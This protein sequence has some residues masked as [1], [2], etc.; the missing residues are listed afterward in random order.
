MNKI[1][2]KVAAFVL[3]L[4]LMTA[5]TNNDE[6]DNGNTASAGS[7]Y[8]SVAINLNTAGGSRADG[9]EDT[10]GNPDNNF[11]GKWAGKDK[12]KTIDVYV[13]NNTDRLE[14]YQSF[15]AG[16]FQVQGAAAD[17]SVTITPSKGIKVLPGDKKVYVVVNPTTETQNFLPHVVNTTTLTE[18]QAKYEN[19]ADVAT[20][21]L[22]PAVENNL[23]ATVKTPA[24]KIASVDSDNTDVITMTAIELASVTVVDNVSEAATLS[25]NTTNRAKLTVKRAV[26]RVMVTTKAESFEIKGDDALTAT[27]ETDEVLGTI[28]NIK[29]V[30][31]QGEKSLYFMQRKGGTTDL[32]YKTPNSSYVANGTNYTWATAGSMYD[33]SGLWKNSGSTDIKGIPVPTKAL[34]DATAS[35][36]LSNITADLVTQLNGEFI[37]PNTHTWGATQDASGYRKANTAYILVRAQFTPK[38]VVME[39][40]NIN[41]AYTEGKTFY[42]GANGV[43]YE[44]VTAAR[45]AS[46]KG[47]AGQTAAKYENGKVLYFAWINPDH[48]DTGKWINSPINRNN[49]YHVQINGFKRIGANWNPLVPNHPENPT[50]PTKNPNN[51]DPKP[52]DETPE[53][54]NEPENPPVDPKDPLTPKET[55]MSVQ[56]TILPWNVHS[57]AVILDI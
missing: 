56:T 17:H 33:Y 37:L 50:D 49:I 15:V 55:W 9:Q 23:T 11:V 41:D 24:D 28:K 14:A 30:V 20:N 48:A 16:Q 31:A 47:V 43:F 40:G 1:L 8:M 39:N 5:C 7:T 34:Y 6:P 42:L 12:I 27:V 38:K 2:V 45:D 53:N 36:A 22:A 13:F 4:G 57:Y 18:F 52:G 21:N 44:S 10:A 54:P 25:G 19:V 35:T 3:G 26:A 29:Y 32:T 46:K 51:P